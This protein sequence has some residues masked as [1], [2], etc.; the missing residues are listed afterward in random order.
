M[1]MGEEAPVKPKPTLSL[2]KTSQ[3][4]G[5]G[6]SKKKNMIVR[7]RNKKRNLLGKVKTIQ[8][9]QTNSAFTPYS[10][11]SEEQTAA[12]TPSAQPVN[13]VSYICCSQICGIHLPSLNTDTELYSKLKLYNA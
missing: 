8:G 13:N 5:E 3:G 9:G 6:N 1:E 4:S 2:A 7:T 12:T 11:P 10:R